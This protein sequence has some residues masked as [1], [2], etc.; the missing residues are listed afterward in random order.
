[1]L[2]IRSLRHE[3]SFILNFV[4]TYRTRHR[5]RPLVNANIQ[6]ALR[7]SGGDIAIAQ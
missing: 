2:D 1:M 4:P 6:P 7:G 3:P 5:R